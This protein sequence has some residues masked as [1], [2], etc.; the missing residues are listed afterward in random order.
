MVV[1]ESVHDEEFEEEFGATYRA[2]VQVAYQI[3]GSVEEAEDAAAEGLARALVEW[4]KVRRLPYRRAWILRVTANVAIDA[5]RRRRTA[6]VELDVA[7]DL[8]EATVLRLALLAALKALPRRQREVIVLRYLAGLPELEVAQ[9]L[10]IS[11]NSV[12]T[13]SARALSTLRSSVGTAWEERSL[14]V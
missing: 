14:A 12:K 10:S 8:A 3:V 9:C 13:H 1:G 11:P 7:A 4:R 6:P 2:A 5:V